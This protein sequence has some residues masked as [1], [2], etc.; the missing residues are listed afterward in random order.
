MTG[1]GSVSAVSMFCLLCAVCCDLLTLSHF[2]LLF[3]GG[4]VLQDGGADG[5]DGA[6]RAAVMMIL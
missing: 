6:R 2:D 3:D 4:G 1:G 5:A